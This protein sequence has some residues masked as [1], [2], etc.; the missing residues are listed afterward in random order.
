MDARGRGWSSRNGQ[1]EKPYLHTEPPYIMW[2][3]YFAIYRVFI[4]EIFLNVYLLR[5]CT[6]QPVQLNQLSGKNKKFT[7]LILF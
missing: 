6:V 2:Y 1:K 7:Q 3:G 5:R 4:S